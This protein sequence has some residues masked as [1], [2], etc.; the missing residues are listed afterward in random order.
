MDF[1]IH[2][3]PKEHIMIKTEHTFIFV[4]IRPFLPYH[5]L[6]SPIEKIQ[7]LYDLSIEQTQ[8][9]FVC[10]H[11]ALKALKPFGED[12]TVSTQDGPAAGQTV[13]HVHVHIIPRRENDIE[14]NNL[15]YAKGGLDYSRR[16]RTNEEMG[17]EALYLR[18]LFEKTFDENNY[19]YQQ[20]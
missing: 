12:F 2:I 18:S 14:N 15:I 8:D 7:H 11:L 4:N 17:D 20:I 3:I 6:V 9:L 13:N 5:I 1:G 10:V 16:T 19:K